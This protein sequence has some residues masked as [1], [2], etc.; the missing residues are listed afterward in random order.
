MNQD[1]LNKN[2][3]ILNPIDEEID[4]KNYNK[5]PIDDNMKK[6][7]KKANQ[8]IRICKNDIL[9]EDIPVLLPKKPKITS[10]IT[11]YNSNLTITTAIRSIQNQNMSQIEIIVID[12]CSTNNNLEKIMMLQKEDKRIKLL[13]NKENKGPLYNRA[14][15]VLFA[16]AN[17]IMFL[18][19][20]DL[21]SNTNIFDICYKES[22]NKKHI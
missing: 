5:T 9:L 20:D 1:K 17:F 3:N 6:I 22:I 14:I 13:K 2:D 10:I 12:D 18:D 11:S 21:F 16:K 4:E 7:M 19:S 8:F 15:G